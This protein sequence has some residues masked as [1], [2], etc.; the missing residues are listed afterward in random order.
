MGTGHSGLCINSGRK[1]INNNMEYSQL[2]EAGAH[3][4]HLTRKWNPKMAP[5]IF[6]E[7]RGIHIL[8][9]KKTLA[10][11]QRACDFVEQYASQGKTILFVG[12]KPQARDV[13]VRE[14]SRLRQP[15]VTERWLGGML[16]NFVT[17]RRT[18]KR[19]QSVDK[20][21][22]DSSY[23]NLAKRERL[24][25]N[26]YRIKQERVFG[27]VAEMSR[28]PDALILIDSNY[29]SIAVQEALRL[30]IPI[31]AVLDTNCDPSN[32]DYPIPANDD[33]IKAITLLVE[34]LSQAIDRGVQL[35]KQRP[36][37][38]AAATPQEEEKPSKRRRMVRADEAAA[39]GEKTSS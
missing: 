7:R 19:L 35:A 2:L 39:T 21:I 32:I 3:F 38:A 1:R 20:L 28:P 25:L 37:A 30:N 34:T 17:I 16:T 29:E 12:T 5:Y 4:G 8:D 36:V 15:Y 33:S 24:L 11:L 27:G 18:L 14:A 23:K 13:I 22:R 6:L 26:R 9:L 31:V 10:H